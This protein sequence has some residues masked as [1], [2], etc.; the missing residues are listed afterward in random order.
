MKILLTFSLFFY[1][2]GIFACSCSTGNK[3]EQIEN[4]DFVAQV[5]VEDIERDPVNERYW[6]LDIELIEVFKSK[7]NNDLKISTDESMCNVYTPKNTEWLIYASCD[8]NGELSFNYCS[9]AIQLDRII[10]FDKYPN[11]QETYDRLNDKE[12]TF[13]RYLND[14]NNIP[15]TDNN[16]TT[17]ISWDCLEKIREYEGKEEEFALLEVSIEKDLSVSK[18]RFL[19]KFSN[20]IR[21]ETLLNCP[22]AISIRHQKRR[23]K[24][25]QRTKE[26]ISV[27][28]YPKN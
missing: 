13:L 28:Y 11:A 15:Q 21:N 25:P 8:N 24:I 2:F 19:K 9:R 26:L 23:D 22:E 12:L 6:N 5:T 17:D 14:T 20:P 1:S 4:A 18:I 27:Y 7:F 10:K 16:V 3:I